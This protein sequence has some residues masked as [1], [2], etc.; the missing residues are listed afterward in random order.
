MRRILVNNNVTLDGVMQSP[1]TKGE[2]DRGGFQHGG[3]AVPYN[4]PAMFEAAAEGSGSTEL[5]FG[6]RT[7][8]QFY[9]Y[10]PTAPQPNP[11]TDLLNNAQKYVCSR[12]LTEPLPWENSKLLSGDAADS[13]AKLKEEPGQD[14]VVLGSGELIQTLLRY[15]LIDGLRLLIFPLVLSSGQRLFTE[16]AAFTPFELIDTVTTKTGV[17]IATY[18]LVET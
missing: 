15:Q 2:D 14:L 7:Y 10:W 8:E 13:V 9:A 18:R 4:D 5:L 12:T 1:S 6:R 11:F 17:V 3:W 16:R